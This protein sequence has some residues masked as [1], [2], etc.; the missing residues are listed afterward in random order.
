MMIPEEAS[1]GC[2]IS[3]ELKLHR[4]LNQAMEVLGTKFSS[5]LFSKCSEPLSLL[6]GPHELNTF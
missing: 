3:E 2:H 1:R 6:S 4:V 5:S